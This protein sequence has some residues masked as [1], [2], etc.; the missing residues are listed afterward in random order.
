MAPRI[1]AIRPVVVALTLIGFGD[2]SGHIGRR[3]MVPV[4]L[5]APLVGTL[6]FAMAP[7]VLWLFAAWGPDGRRPHCRTLDRGGSGIRCGRPGGKHN[8]RALGTAPI[9]LSDD[10]S[11]SHCFDALFD[12]AVRDARSVRW[13]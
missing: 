6:P 7:D 9:R 10:R 11:Q 12:S 8:A 4:G 1:F 13:S 2:T 3:A 5:G